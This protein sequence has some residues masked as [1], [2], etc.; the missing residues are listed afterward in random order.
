RFRRSLIAAGD[1]TSDL[2]GAALE[3]SALAGACA[4]LDHRPWAA[5]QDRIARLRAALR[6]KA[7]A[8]IAAAAAIDSGPVDLP[9][10]TG[11]ANQLFLPPRGLVLCLGPDPDSLLDQVVQALALGNAVVAAAPGAKAALAPLS[12]ND[13]PLA[14]LEGHPSDAAL[15]EAAVEAVAYAGGGGELRRLRRALAARSGPILTLIT[16]RIAPAAYCTERSLCVDTTAA[17]GN[18]SLLSAAE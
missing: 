1:T 4:G 9:G 12:A 8:A 15:A 5:A 6:G 16:A 7:A 18:A 10:P 2:A 13:L 3:A 11:E 14:V 17:G